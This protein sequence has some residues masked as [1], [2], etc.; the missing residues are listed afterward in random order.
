MTYLPQK[1]QSGQEFM[2]ATVRAV[3]G[4][5]D[6]LHSTRLVGDG[7]TIKVDQTHG[8]TLISALPQNSVGGTASKFRYLF[9]LDIGQ[10]E[11]GEPVMTV[12]SLRTHTS[13]DNHYI[14]QVPLTN[15]PEDGTYRVKC[16]MRQSD[17]NGM[18]NAGYTVYFTPS[19][20]HTG[21]GN[22]PNVRG[23]FTFQLGSI[24]RSTTTI[25]EEAV[26]TY[27]VEHQ[28]TVGMVWLQDWEPYSDFSAHVIL[29]REGFGDGSYVDT[30]SLDDFTLAVRRGRIYRSD[31]T[32]ISVPEANFPLSSASDAVVV[33]NSD[34]TLE[35]RTR[36]RL[37]AGEYLIAE[38]KTN[39]YN[40]SSDYWV[41]YQ[42]MCG[43]IV[44]GDKAEDKLVAVN[45]DG[46]PGY[47]ANKLISSDGTVSFSYDSSA[48]A[49]DL[50]AQ[51]AEGPEG[52]QGPQG[53]QGPQGPQGETGPQGPQGEQ[54]PKGDK[55]D[56][57]EQGPRGYQGEQG[58]Q[59]PQGPKG[60]QGPQGP[61]GP[62]GDKGDPGNPADFSITGTS[63]ITAMQTQGGYSI[64]LDEQT[65]WNHLTLT[66]Q[67]G[68]T[69]GGSGS[70]RT[71]GNALAGKIMVD[72]YDT[73][74]AYLG[75]KITG[76]TPISVTTRMADETVEIGLN[77]ITSSSNGIVI[78]TNGVFSVVP[79]GNGVLVG[80]NGSITWLP[81]QSCNQ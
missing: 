32:Y 7:R 4:I 72:E 76:R 9:Q 61:Q 39:P 71:I 43:S 55:G 24:I 62:K 33:L 63:P 53:E 70:A 81:T 47:L 28:D 66:G 77:N 25:G 75:S 65:L 64:T 40:Y 17:R 44:L 22:E 13:G 16:M 6:Y 15:I 14:K 41:L 54:G 2:P 56:T 11:D 20:H 19:N 46:E 51:G 29:N 78:C 34:H 59:G 68:I 35:L 12:N 73:T 37:E 36:T 74:P 8:G 23:I 45:S 21:E 79:I 60:E 27:R 3:N 48:D 38:L 49:L 80:A 10:N 26:T 69:M 5:I 57:G 1:L 18:F 31:G 52:P 67:D 50:S 58:I 30:F 42:Y